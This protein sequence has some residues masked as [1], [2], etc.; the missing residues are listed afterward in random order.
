MLG[1]TATEEELFAELAFCLLTPQS[2][3]HRCDEA[4]RGLRASGLLFRGSSRQIAAHLRRR[5][6]FHNHK[7]R[8][9]VEARRLFSRGG[10]IDV[11][12]SLA[13]LGPLEARG[14][15]VEHVEGLGLKEATHF[16]RNI[17]RSGDLAILDRHILRN[18]VA[19]GALPRIP[20]SLTPRR[21]AS[22]E[23]R[24]Q[25][26]AAAVGI[27]PAELDLLFW[28]DATGEVFK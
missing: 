24:F 21:Y 28:S 25:A 14:W 11:R 1:R 18:L 10:G 17:G 9:L 3:A 15:L 19:Q 26:F 7:A 16:L 2:S 6:R 8:Y 20:R 27:P 22:V 13:G 23:R 4:V 12:S 5:V